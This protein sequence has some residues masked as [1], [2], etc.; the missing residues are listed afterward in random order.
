MIGHGSGASRHGQVFEVRADSPSAIN[1]LAQRTVAPPPTVP[2][3]NVIG[4][5][6]MAQSHS[7]ELVSRIEGALDRLGA[8]HHSIDP[9][10]THE[11][12]AVNGT[13]LWQLECRLTDQQALMRRLSYALER[14]LSVV[15]E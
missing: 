13:L 1:Q 7:H 5:L 3:V 11:A 14:L 4:H 9:Q 12:A 10:P 8:P 2:M 6:D 15:P